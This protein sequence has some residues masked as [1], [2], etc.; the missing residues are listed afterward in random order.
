MQL[1]EIRGVG[2]RTLTLLKKLKIESIDDLLTHYP[3]RYEEYPAPV[4]ISSVTVG[5]CAIM[6]RIEGKICEGNNGLS[7]LYASDGTGG[8]ALKWF[9]NPYIKKYLEFGKVYV[10]YGKVTEFQGKLSFIQ[11]NYMKSEDYMDRVGSY[12]PVYSL[13]TGISNDTLFKIILWALTS[14][15][16]PEDTLPEDIRKKYGLISYGD[17]LRC[18]HYPGNRQALDLAR[19]RIIFGEFYSL[20]YGIRERASNRGENHYRIQ[21][22]NTADMVV[23][24]LPYEL[25]RS[26]KNAIGDIMEDFGKDLVVNRLVQGDVGCGKSLVAFI[27][28]IAMADNGYQSVLM[29][30]T[31][32]LATQHYRE[33]CVLLEKAGKMDEFRPV[34]LTGSVKE[35]E[36]VKIRELI[37]SGESRIIIGTHAVIQEKVEY[38]DLALVVIDEQHRFGV[39]QREILSGK[40][41]NPAHTVVMT[42]TPIPRT[43][44]NILFGGMDISI[45]EDKP[46][47]RKE[48]ISYTV[49]QENEETVYLQLVAGELAAGHQAYVI[50]PAVEGEEKKSVGQC[51]KK[52]RKLFPSVLIGE[53]YGRMDP[54]KKDKAMDLFSKGETQILVSTT[55]VEVGVDVPNATVIV[56]EAAN[57]FGMLQLHQLRGRVGRGDAQ[58]Y[59]VFINSS[60]GPNKKL[61]VLSGTN[62][63]FEIAE[64]DYRLRKAGE[65]LGTQQ[66]GDMG[67]KLADMVRDEDILKEAEEAVGAQYNKETF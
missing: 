63:G 34:L 36:K 20:L 7:Y 47:G 14:M 30:P 10:F 57:N 58:S 4:K 52:L 48:I 19:H 44:G 32:V 61:D 1:S 41:T 2:K 9:H 67:F 23:G 64:A 27:S 12:K 66:S 42:A 25:T 16:E 31:E 33:L 60:G 51:A 65:L 56:I 24:Q 11:P 45:M 62:D 22:S 37:S 38:H 53:L 35:K 15:D 43:T 21:G 55:V 17:A 26:Q 29:A 8:I 39:E 5:R 6:C 59:C 50:C 18:I 28:M 3:R 46:A 13:T 49:P 40:G 54:K